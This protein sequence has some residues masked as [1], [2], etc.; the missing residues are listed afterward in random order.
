MNPRVIRCGIVGVIPRVFWIEQVMANTNQ[1]MPLTHAYGVRPRKDHRG[2]GKD[3]STRV[4]PQGTRISQPFLPPQVFIGRRF[5]CC[6]A[7]S[8]GSG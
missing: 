2:V 3:V 6:Y 8:E 5:R 1:A 4:T 7:T